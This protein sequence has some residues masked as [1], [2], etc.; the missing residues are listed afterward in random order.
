MR[1]CLLFLFLL[2]LIFFRCWPDQKY[3][4]LLFLLPPYSLKLGSSPYCCL[5]PCAKPPHGLFQTSWLFSPSL[6]HTSPPGSCWGL[7]FACP[8]V[9]L[10]SSNENLEPK[11]EKE[12]A[13]CKWQVGPLSNWNSDINVFSFL[14]MLIVQPSSFSFSGG[15]L[16]CKA[17]VWPKGTEL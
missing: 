5:L 16:E 15:T 17:R 6:L 1:S 11:E 14:G 2:F 4:C 9:F 12:F 3:C 7:H 8:G 10:L 13:I